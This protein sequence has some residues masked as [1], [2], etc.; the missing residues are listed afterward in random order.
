MMIL[1]QPRGRRATARDGTDDRG[2]KVKLS[3]IIFFDFNHLC[4]QQ[5][6]HCQSSSTPLIT[7]IMIII[8]IIIIIIVIIIMIIMINTQI[9]HQPVGGESS[10]H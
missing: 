8:A 2:E 9:A 4:H 5:H 3:M 6:H 10:R 7:I 1:Q